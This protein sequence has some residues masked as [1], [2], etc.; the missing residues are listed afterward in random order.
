MN[1]PTAQIK[2]S[3]RFRKKNKI[4]DLSTKTSIIPDD[5]QIAT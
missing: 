4:Q 2:T 3:R 1:T 5:E